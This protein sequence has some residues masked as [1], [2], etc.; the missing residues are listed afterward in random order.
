MGSH[1]TVILVN[2][3]RLAVV[4]LATGTAVAQ[5]VTPAT[6]A[7]PSPDVTGA[8]YLPATRPT[9]NSDSAGKPATEPPPQRVDVAFSGGKVTV[10]A[11]NASLS[12]VLHEV[13]DKAG[14]KITGGVSDEKVF[15]HYGPDS[16]A[17]ILATLLDGTGANMLLVDDKKGGSELILTQRVG[18]PTPPSPL[19]AALETTE[20]SEGRPTSRFVP[21]GRGF[22]PPGP[23]RGP[24][25]FP[26]NLAT[27]PPQSIYPAGANPSDPSQ[28]SNG[29]QTPQQI[30]DQLQNQ[31]KQTITQSPQ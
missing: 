2:S 15:G 21:P 26:A 8:A 5:I 16:P 29:A 31:Q 14:I 3:I 20:D 22:P 19:A 17:I 24:Q 23:G 11:T 13:A 9:D 6:P 30:Y 4:L 27:P 1:K 7:K 25:T 28:Q 12:K 18:G 10:D